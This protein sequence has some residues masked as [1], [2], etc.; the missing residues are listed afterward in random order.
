LAERPGV[1][2]VETRYFMEILYI[3]LILLVVTRTFGELAI[4]INQP[5][6]VGE[7]VGGVLLGLLSSI[8][9]TPFLFYPVCL[10]TMFLPRLQIWE[11]SLSCFWAGWK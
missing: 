9:R 11:Y 10:K 3:L 8:S 2:V 4:R 1:P 6:L 7:L 5:A